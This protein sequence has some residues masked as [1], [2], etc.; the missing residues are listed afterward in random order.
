[1]LCATQWIEMRDIESFCEQTEKWWKKKKKLRYKRVYNGIEYNA[2][3]YT[4][5][6]AV[7]NHVHLLPKPSMYATD[8]N[9][10]QGNEHVLLSLSCSSFSLSLCAHQILLLK[11]AL[12][13]YD[14]FPYDDDKR[15]R[16]HVR[17]H[18]I[19]DKLLIISKI[20]SHRTY[21]V[22]SHSRSLVRSNSVWVCA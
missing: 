14:R 21:F 20:F 4:V 2:R 18:L 7:V 15:S 10:Q 6:V 19:L 17:W 9:Q 8:Y 22:F 3:C 12:E 5:R 13:L 16:C 1:M 11:Y